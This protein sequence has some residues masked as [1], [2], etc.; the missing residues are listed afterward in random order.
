MS[1]TEK[2]FW[3]TAPGVITA[4]ATLVTALGGVLAILVQN[5]IIGGA[6]PV[7]SQV[8]SAPSEGGPAIPVAPESSAASPSDA[9]PAR[10]VETSPATSWAASTAVLVRRN[11]TSA[12][13]KAA[14]VGL[15]C[16]PGTVEF[17]NGQRVSMEQVGSIQ[18]DA[19]YTENGS[20]DGV[21]TL[22]DGRTLTEPMHT[23]NCPVSG[24]NELGPLSIPLTDI[25]R[26]EFRR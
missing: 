11:G 22:L 13:V 18:F 8:A 9:T 1:E 21:V 3:H 7:E 15:A 2:S 20:A 10:P 4:V 26:I 25:R 14:T 17:K 19:V 16:N 5:D 12:T 6:D 23:W 24:A